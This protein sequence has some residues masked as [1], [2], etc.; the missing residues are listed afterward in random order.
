LIFDLY[1]IDFRKEAVEQLKEQYHRKVSHMVE[2]GIRD[3]KDERKILLYHGTSLYYLNVILLNGLQ[4]RGTT[5]RNNFKSLESNEHLVYLTNKWHYFYASVAHSNLIEE[6]KGIP[7]WNI[8]CYIEVEVPYKDLIIDEDF[9]HSHYV[10]GT[11]KN[12]IKKRERYM[13]LNANESLTKYATVGHIGTVTREMIKSFT[14][15]ANILK[16]HDGFEDKNSQYQKD[17]EHWGHGKGRGILAFE[18][19][20]QIEDDSMN[21][22][23][24]LKDLPKDYIVTKFIPSDDEEK[25]F[26]LYFGRVEFT[27]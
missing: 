13:E 20:L 14:V 11:L 4:P 6:G 23:F 5:D 10:L 17:L 19:L 18:D 3:S 12:C 24:F 15:L 2:N 26:K 16:F 8:P 22:T 1:Q 27:K 9:F 25:K 7:D 21:L